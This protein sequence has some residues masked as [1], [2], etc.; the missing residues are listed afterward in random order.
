MAFKPEH[1]P[2]LLQENRMKNNGRVLCENCGTAVIPP[3]KSMRGVTPPKNEWQRDHIIPKA[4]RGDGDP[5]NGQ[6]LCRGCNRA[7][8]AK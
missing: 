8:G 6:I 2:V 1:T 4:Q 7:K 3:Q 5:R